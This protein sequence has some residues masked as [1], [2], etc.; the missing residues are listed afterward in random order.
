MNITTT[1]LSISVPEV[2]DAKT[3]EYIDTFYIEDII[4]KGGFGN[5]YRV[6]DS[7]Y[8][9]AP[10]QALKMIRLWES[11][12]EVQSMIMKRFQMEYNCCRNKSSNLIQAH[13]IGAIRGNPY[14]VMDYCPGGALRRRLEQPW[15]HDKALNLA[16]QILDGLQVLHKQGIV[17]RD[18]KPDNILFDAKDRVR[19]TD[20]GIA[21]FLNHRLTKKKKSWEIFGTDIYL[22]PEQHDTRKAYNT[23]LP[24]TDIFSFGILMYEVLSGGKYPFGDPKKDYATYFSNLKKDNITPLGKQGAGGKPV[25]NNILDKCLSPRIEDRYSSVAEVKSDLGHKNELVC[26][27]CGKIVSDTRF[28]ECPYCFKNSGKGKFQLKILKGFEPEKI[29][30]LEL[31]L[32]DNKHLVTL[33]RYDFEIGA[34]SDIAVLDDEKTPYISRCHASLEWDQDI[35]RWFIRDGQWDTAARRWKKS[36]NGT[37]V[38]SNGAGDRRVTLFPGDIITLGDTTIRFERRN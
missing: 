27:R 37:F 8:P 2:F 22:P 15:T 28:S 5:V 23:V 36:I 30:D 24:A 21:G 17:H 20:F 11:Q 29:Y 18:L 33:G 38:N 16:K 4:G 14:F 25:W 13:C 7:L 1:T 35:G 9:A 19:I 31:F 34:I 10:M 12:G 3:G 32:N 26:S 6:R